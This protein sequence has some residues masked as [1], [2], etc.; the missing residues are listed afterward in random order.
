MHVGYLDDN[1]CGPCHAYLH[2]RFELY[3]IYYMQTTIFTLYM[4]GRNPIITMD[5]CL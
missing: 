2:V 5:D 3:P 1:A 4:Y